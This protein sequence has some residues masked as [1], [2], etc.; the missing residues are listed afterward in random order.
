MKIKYDINLMKFMSLFES[1]TRAKLKDCFV[2]E[3]S[4]KLVFVVQEYQIRQALGKN[5]SNVRRLEDSLKRK[6]KIVQYSSDLLDFVK[7][8]IHPLKADN[9]E[10][11]E[12]IVT[13]ASDDTKT[14][15]LLIGKGGQNL[16]AAE[17]AI[18]RYFD[19]KEVKVV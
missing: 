15:G 8:W 14:K 19:I 18:K 12:G 6:I 1:L 16:R 17:D 3:K 4:E 13:I 9:I 7:N 2:D 5:A 11:N 10:E